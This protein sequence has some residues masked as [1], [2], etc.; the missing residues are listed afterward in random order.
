MS[1]QTRLDWPR[2]VRVGLWR[3][4]SRAAAFAFVW[5]SIGLALAG[6]IAGFWHPVLF[7]AVLF[8]LAAWWYWRAIHWVDK[9]ASW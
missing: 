1:A 8:I 3:V 4:P 6:L 2:W 5:L 9:N 7:V